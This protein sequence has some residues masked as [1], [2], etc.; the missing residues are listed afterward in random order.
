M[1]VKKPIVKW[2]I[3]FLS[4][5]MLLASA[6]CGSATLE[7]ATGLQTSAPDPITTPATASP[8][9]TPSPTPMPEITVA[10]RL[11][12]NPLSGLYTMDPA[13]VG[14]R[15]VGVMFSN[16]QAALPQSGIASADLYYE[17][18]VEGGYTRIMALYADVATIPEI[19][20]IRSARNSFVDMAMG[21]DAL[22][23]HFGASVICWNYMAANDLK[24]LDWQFH[25]AGYWRDPVIAAEKGA[26]HSVKSN[27]ERI[28]A[29]IAAKGMRDTL[30]AGVGAAFDFRD[31]DASVPADGEDCLLFKIPFSSFGSSPTAGFTYE[32]AG[33]TYVKSQHGAPQID[34]LTG[35]P[36]RVANA[37][38]LF[39]EI[40][41]LSPYGHVGAR[42]TDGGTGYYLSGG[43]I[44]EIRWEKGD[45]Y[46]P[47]TFSAIDGTV[48]KVN[49]GK[50]YVCVVSNSQKDDV[51]IG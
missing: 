48:L 23:V 42:L 4:L 36:I 41:P 14:K 38:I 8:T 25:S 17:M 51:T 6:A 47:F 32:P 18:V 15:P 20:S 26:E 29:A 46:D 44:Q 43:K 37:F 13:N 21:F 3:R 1:Q 45:I 12:F 19:G 24:T 28:K 40:Y 7:P 35:E 10:P 5:W 31:P 27:A 2:F 22:L 50:S 9:V 39:T 33:Q 30:E 34:L 16:I 11:G 49:A